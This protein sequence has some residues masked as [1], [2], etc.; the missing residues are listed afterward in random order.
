MFYNEKY[1]IKSCTCVYA[2]KS[3]R[4][5]LAYPFLSDQSL[6]YMVCPCNPRLLSMHSAMAAFVEF[7]KNAAYIVEIFYFFVVSLLNYLI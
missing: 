6:A 1:N 5:H 3:P 4:F 2:N 7:P